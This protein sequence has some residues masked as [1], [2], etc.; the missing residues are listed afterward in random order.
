M[1]L[2]KCIV[3][4]ALLLM[5]LQ[6]NAQQ[7]VQLKQI[8]K[9]HLRG[10]TGDDY[11]NGLNVKTDR[12]LLVAGRYSTTVGNTLSIDFPNANTLPTSSFADGMLINYGATG[13]VIWAQRYNN[14][15]NDVYYG[16]TSTPNGTPY[17]VGGVNTSSSATDF[18]HFNLVISSA[19]ITT[20]ALTHSATSNGSTINLYNTV[21]SDVSG[22]LYAGGKYGGNPDFNFGRNPSVTLGTA[23]GVDACLVKHDA[24]RNVIWARRIGG[25]GNDEINSIKIVGNSI[26]ITGVFTGKVDFN[27]STATADTFFLQTPGSAQNGYLLRLDT[28]GNFINA[29]TLAGTALTY[30]TDVAIANNGDMYVSAFFNGTVDADLGTAVTNITSAGAEDALI[31]KMNAAGNRIWHRTFGGTLGDQLLKIEMNQTGDVYACGFFRSTSVD[32]G[33]PGT[34]VLTNLSTAGNS[35]GI[36]V[37]YDPNG[38]LLFGNNLGGSGNDVISAI[39]IDTIDAALY[40]ALNFVN[41][42]NTELI[43]GQPASNTTSGGLIDA[44]VIKYTTICPSVI[45]QPLSD[46]AGCG[47][48]TQLATFFTGLNNVYQWKR[49]GINLTNGAKYSG[50]ND[51]TL[52]ISNLQQADSGLFQLEVTRTGCPTVYGKAIRVYPAPAQLSVSPINHYPLDIDY[53]DAITGYAA[54]MTGGAATPSTANRFS[55]SNRAARFFANSTNNLAIQPVSGTRY[56]ISLWINRIDAA[57]GAILYSSNSTRNELAVQDG[58]LGTFRTG[59]FL[60]FGPDININTWYHIVYIKDSLTCRVYLNGVPIFD[61]ANFLPA[62]T[63]NITHISS[64]SLAFPGAIDEVRIF[65]GVLNDVDVQ[66]LYVRGEVNSNLNSTA[67]CPAGNIILPTRVFNSN[68]YTLQWLKDG[69]PLTNNANYSG[70]N[71]D[72]LRMTNVFQNMAGVYTLRVQVGCYTIPTHSINLAVQTSPL[73]IDNGL[74]AQYTFNGNLNDVLGN[75]NMSG[76]VI[77]G[78]TSRFGNAINKLINA[79]SF[80]NSLTFTPVSNDTLSVALWW[81]AM[82]GGSNRALLSGNNGSAAHLFVNNANEVGFRLPNGTFVTSGVAINM[83]AWHHFVVTKNGTNQ[84]IYLNGQLIMNVNNSFLNSVANNSLARIVNTSLSD[85][86]SYGHYDDMFIYN[87]ELNQIEAM[88]LMNRFYSD[89]NTPLVRACAGSGSNG[90]LGFANENTDTTQYLMQWYFNNTPIS[91]GAKYQGVNGDTLQIFNITAADTGIYRLMISPASQ[92]C[93]GWQTV[94]FTRV[95]LDVSSTISDNLRWYLKLNNNVRDASGNNLSATNSSTTFTNDRFGTSNAAANFDGTQRYISAN[96]VVAV[97]APSITVSAWFRSNLATGG[98]ISSVNNLPP[99]NPTSSHAL[100]YIGTDNKLH[101]KSWNGN[102]TYMSSPNDVNDNQWHHAALVVE[103]N[104]SVQRLYLDGVLVG[105]LA[106]TNSSI[107]ST[108]IVGAAFGNSTNW[109]GTTNGWNY[110]QGQIDEVRTYN[111]ALSAEEISRLSQNIGF[112]DLGTQNPGYCINNPAIIAGRAQG[113]GLTYSWYRNGVLISNTGNITGTNTDTLRIANVTNADTGF[114]NLHISRNCLTLVSD[115]F[116]FRIFNGITITQSVQNQNRCVGD[117]VNLSA[118]ATGAGLTYQWYRGSSPLVNSSKY[119]GVNNPTLTIYNLAYN[120]LGMYR[121]YIN[122]QCGNID[123]SQSS[124][125]NVI[126][127]TPPVVPAAL[128]TYLFNGNTDAD[129]V[130]NNATGTNV[131]AATNRYGITNNAL[132]FT[133][134]NSSRVL[135]PSGMSITGKAQYTVSLWF[136]TSAQNTCMGLFGTTNAIPNNIPT[137][138]NPMLYIS[139]TGQLT[140]KVYNGN[141]TVTQSAKVDDGKWHH[142]ALTYTGTT[143]YVY[144]DGE[145]FATYTGALQGGTSPIVLVG[146]TYGNGWTGHTAGWAF[147]DGEID[148]VRIHGVRLQNEQIKEEY[149]RGELRSA[150]NIFTCSSQNQIGF[151]SGLFGTFSNYQWRKN[152][153]IIN[154][155]S[156]FAGTNT[157]SLTILNYTFAD[158]GSYTCEV[159]YGCISLTSNANIVTQAN[160]PVITTQPVNSSSCSGGSVVLTV[161]ATGGGISYQWRKNGIPLNNGGNISGA[162]SASLTISSLA[163]SDTAAYSCVLTNVCGTATTIN[164]HVSINSGLQILQQPQSQTACNG[165]NPF[166]YVVTSDPNATF[167]WRKNGI[168][169]ANSNNDTLYFNNVTISDGGNYSVAISSVCGSATSNTAELTVINSATISTH[170][171]S[172]TGCFGKQLTL[173]VVAGGSSINYQWRK[174]GVNISGANSNTYTINSY[175]AND[176]GNY[177]CVVTN[178]CNSITSNTAVVTNPSTVSITTQP[179]TFSSC[180]DNQFHNL[181]IAYTGTV[182]SINWFKDGVQLSNITNNIVGVNSTN[183]SFRSNS[184][185]VGVYTCRLITACD[186]IFSQAASF[187]LI[188]E[189]TLVSGPQSTS[190]CNGNTITMVAKFSNVH[191]SA[192][193]M[194]FHNG[195]ALSNSGRVSGAMSDSLVITNATTADSGEYQLSVTVCGNTQYTSTA[196]VNIFSS[197]A[198]TGQSA[199]SVN[200]CSS[201][202]V[203]LYVNANIATSTYQWKKNGVNISGAINDTLIINAAT[204]TDNGTY[205]CEVTSACGNTTSS[206]IVVTINASPAPT[207]TQNGAILT[208]QTFDT[209]QWRRNGGNLIGAT[210]QTYTPTQSGNYTVTVSQ[211]GC[212]ATSPVYAFTFSGIEDAYRSRSVNWYPNPAHRSLTIQLTEMGNA[213][214]MIMNINGQLI[215]KYQLSEMTNEINIDQLVPGMYVLQIIKENELILVDKFIKQ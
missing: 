183:L 140:G 55:V 122:D 143:Q 91:N 17:A 124:V 90:I 24:N 155:G 8:W 40:V 52:I 48:T 4:A 141:I 77:Y 184:G 96:G 39:A 73:G 7:P 165:G 126:S 142:A 123:S 156:K 116:R 209:Y 187:S 181:T 92:S 18:N 210:Q 56:S 101:G 166:L 194:W 128:A 200:S 113:S 13:N 75:R 31:I 54:V 186:T 154:D 125:I 138:Y 35:D 65:S 97:S 26:Y 99:N 103:G 84:K 85:G 38:N 203:L 6:L 197:V 79:N 22:N 153:V 2:N 63:F 208:T 120:D 67:V 174:N 213:E 12:T 110:F 62:G 104:N 201:Q 169:I 80:N 58:K 78:G 36:V 21:V 211:N 206:N 117:T 212:T 28:A 167:T 121:L 144:L 29:W 95:Q 53:R 173:F 207:I 23:S 175:T 168:N 60:N 146:A 93:A 71:S 44:L 191:P 20:G 106:T 157:D 119:T 89:V 131:T 189:P 19:N 30:I 161:N 192:T 72:T 151:R 11:I 180:N 3:Y 66:M 34:R 129:Q 132:T 43:T 47:T 135:L 127:Q 137:T 94:Q 176:S 27:P 51:D 87:R 16:V 158:T 145:L 178:S 136:R 76:T 159:W 107:A 179:V 204:T 170:P 114:Y 115:T 164:A 111:R 64:P 160:T 162:T 69:V 50:A 81:Y 149:M 37:G 199:A 82:S 32:V 185:N 195:I 109:F 112:I 171:Q 74:I 70:V 150:Q 198:I 14:N 214:V 205:V 10:A 88:A 100:L 49:N 46:I 57:N 102:G 41:T 98:I 215:D 1:K 134:S 133:S 5:S 163:V 83:N 118:A 172:T 147:F 45:S 177:T 196:T 182:L 33:F 15:N 61:S 9:K 130:V 190:V 139:T 193:Y 152:G 86:W 25:T 188:A 202:D 105:T 59:S 148:H 108:F 68:S 42:V